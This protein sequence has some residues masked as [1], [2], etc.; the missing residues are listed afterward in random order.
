LPKPIVL[1]A[2]ELSPATVSALGPDFEIK[3]IDGTDRKALL[4]AHATADA[5]LVRSATQVDAEAIAAAKQLK[6]IARAGVG[7]DNVDIKAA[8][9]AGVM[10]VNTPTS[11]IISAA[12][13]AIGHL[14]SL[15]RHIPDANAS[16]KGDKWERNKFTGVELYD[17]TISKDSTKLLRSRSRRSIFKE[18]RFV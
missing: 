17:K 7:L 18:L 15:A 2:E 12:E 10:V 13:L 9:A 11:N 5:I 6:V 16:L 3:N 14:L 8:T 1:I 4:S